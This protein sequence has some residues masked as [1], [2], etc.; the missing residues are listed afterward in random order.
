MF[1]TIN[2]DLLES[3]Y[4]ER[5]CVAYGVWEKQFI[6]AICSALV[7]VSL[8]WQCIL[9]ILAN[10]PRAAAGSTS[11]SLSARAVYFVFWE[12]TRERKAAVGGLDNRTLCVVAYIYKRHTGAHQHICI[13]YT[14]KMHHYALALKHKQQSGET[15]F[16]LSE[17]T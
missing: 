9:Y 15:E 3:Y 16:L 17:R 4:Q 10:G 1:Y 13:A 7:A 5:L 12:A 6:Y 2:I 8:F 11:R 14:H